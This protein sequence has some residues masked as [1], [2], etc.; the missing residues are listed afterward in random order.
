MLGIISP[1]KKKFIKLQIQSLIQRKGFFFL[2][3]KKLHGNEVIYN[4]K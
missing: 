2:K 4:L 3:K 1:P